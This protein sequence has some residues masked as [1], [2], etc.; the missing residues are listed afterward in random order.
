MKKVNVGIIGLGTIGSGVYE[1]LLDNAELIRQRSNVSIIV[2]GVCDKNKKVLKTISSRKDL[3]KTSNAAD[4]INDSEI[5]VIV[6][7][8]GGIERAKHIITAALNN[9]KHV[10]TANKA[11]LSECWR[12]IFPLAEKNNLFI[13]FEASVCGAIPIIRT[14]QECFVGNKI[15]RIYG[16]LNGTTNFI[17]TEMKEKGYSFRKALKIAQEKGIAEKKPE[18]DISGKDSAQKLVILSL[19]GFGQD[20]SLSDVYVEGITEIE[21]QDIRNASLWGYSIKLLAIAKDRPDGLELRVHPT[22]LKSS[23]LLSDVRGEDNAVFVRGDLVGDSLLFGK[24]AGKTPTASSVIGDIAEIAQQISFR[25][26]HIV[27]YNYNYIPEKKKISRIEE[28]SF[29]FYLRFSVIDKPGVLAGISSIL[30][31]NNISIA[32]VFQNERKEGKAVP[33]LVLTHKA[34]EGD[35]RKA[36]TRIN[37]L[38]YV[39]DKTVAIR[40]ES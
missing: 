14:L 15:E 30:A 6:E 13:K 17:L 39:T 2:K 28:L 18:L 22:L 20:I 25:G 12:E 32:N 36:I 9:G 3:I 11:L 40:I 24:G 8:I 21:P 37:K 7:L 5:D 4:L 34:K 10:V 1:A 29:S 31:E 38:S 27:T 19:I 26:K 16:I 33:V 35:M 23:N